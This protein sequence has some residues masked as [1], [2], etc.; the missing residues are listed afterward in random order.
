LMS[1]PFAMVATLIKPVEQETTCCSV[2]WRATSDKIAD[3]W[4]AGERV[5]Q[6]HSIG[7]S[8]ATLVIE[9]VGHQGH[10]ALHDRSHGGG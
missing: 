4:R 1:F 3:N 8:T 5:W 10:A 6:G 9:T 7:R 2:T